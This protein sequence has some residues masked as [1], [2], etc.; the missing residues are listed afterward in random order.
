MVDRI[1][2][3]IEMGLLIKYKVKNIWE[4]NVFKELNDFQTMAGATPVSSQQSQ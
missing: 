3:T 2:V 1:P 4:T